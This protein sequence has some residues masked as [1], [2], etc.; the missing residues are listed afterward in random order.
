MCRGSIIVLVSVSVKCAA[1]QLRCVVFY[2][3]CG[4]VIFVVDAM[5]DHMVEAYSSISLATALYVENIISLCLP[6]LVEERTL[7]MV[8][9]LDALYAVFSASLHLVNVR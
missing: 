9:R 4:L 7:S 2:I 6:H 8:I 5:D 1:M 3:G